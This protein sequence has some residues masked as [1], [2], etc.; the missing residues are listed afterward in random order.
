MWTMGVDVDGFDDLRNDMLAMATA[1]D[2]GESVA[3]ALKEAAVLVAEQMKRNATTD[4]RIVSGD[5]HGAIRVGSV[6]HRKG[7]GKSVTIGIHRKDWH[8]DEYYPAYVEY[9]HGGPAPAPAHPF[10]RPAFD[11]RKEDAYEVLKRV[12]LEELS[13]L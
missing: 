6:K 5:L 7:S 10:A 13:K 12:L 11:T 3:R 1:L 4:P 9:G 8:H 2:Y